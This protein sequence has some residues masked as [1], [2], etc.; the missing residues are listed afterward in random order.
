MSLEIVDWIGPTPAE[1]A[2]AQT[3]QDDFHS[4]NREECAKFKALLE[5]ICPPPNGT[6]F[7]IHTES[8]HDFGAYREVVAKVDEDIADEIEVNSWCSK[9]NHLPGTW[10]EL[11]DIAEGRVRR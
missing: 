2:S 6:C 3:T 7:A 10:L 9:Y 5:K 4:K 11:E 1:E 8:G